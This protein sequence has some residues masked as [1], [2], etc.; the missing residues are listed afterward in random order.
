MDEYAHHAAAGLDTAADG[1]TPQAPST[2]PVQGARTVAGM[3]TSAA[4]LVQAASEHQELPTGNA[5][6]QSPQ[7]PQSQLLLRG[8]EFISPRRLTVGF[9]SRGQITR[10]L[11]GEG[12]LVQALQARLNSHPTAHAGVDVRVLSDSQHNPSAFASLDAV[13][14]V[15]G[16]AFANI[17]ACRPGT[18]VIELSGEWLP[19]TYANLAAA[20]GLE[21]FVYVAEIFP[22]SM[23]D[24]HA[25]EGNGSWVQV[26]STSVA[27]F[28]AKA[29]WTSLRHRL[30]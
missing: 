6:S 9:I 5:P 11:V 27:L 16:G 12:D 24:F 2:A 28:S 26:N 25:R 29:I 3:S 18:V 30:A 15:H 22:T 13:I 10:R 14:G 21:H 8:G 20:I 4:S 23:R 1:S 17:H 7:S 19:R